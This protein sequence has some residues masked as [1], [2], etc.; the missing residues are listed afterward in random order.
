MKY[1]FVLLV[2]LFW[3]AESH[4]AQMPD[5]DY[6]RRHFASAPKDK[7]LCQSLINA[8]EQQQHDPVSLAYLGALQTIR[9]S[10]VLNPL[11]KLQTFEQG[12]NHLE[13]AVRKAPQNPE[14]RL[15]RLSVQQNAPRFLGYHRQIAEDE[16]FVRAHISGVGSPV[17]NDMAGHLLAQKTR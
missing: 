9:A 5:R 7:A 1:F 2:T 15:I 17:L 16:K 10:H 3:M 12:R 13:Q 4:A 11:S 6:V 8:L 14:I